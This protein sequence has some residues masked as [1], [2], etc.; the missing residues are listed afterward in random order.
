MVLQRK[1]FHLIFVLAAFGA[2]GA[3]STNKANIRG[4]SSVKVS[5]T[6]ADAK[7]EQGRRVAKGKHHGSSHPSYGGCFG[8]SE[9]DMEG[10]WIF[11][12]DAPNCTYVSHE[13]STDQIVTQEEVDGGDSNPYDAFLIEQCDTYENLWIWDLSLSCDSESSLDNCNCTFAEELFAA[14]TLTCDDK[15]DCPEDCPICET[16]MTV[17]GCQDPVVRPGSR[18]ST[19]VV[20]YIVGASVIF[21]ILVL[22]T[23]HSYRKSQQNAELKTGLMDGEFPKDDS[24]PAN[25]QHANWEPPISGAAAA[26]AATG[27]Y[28]VG[29]V[30]KG[31]GDSETAS[32]G[33][34]PTIDEST[35][36][37]ITEGSTAPSIPV[38]AD[39]ESQIEEPT[40][41]AA[42]ASGASA[43]E[44]AMQDDAE[45]EYE[46]VS[47][48]Y[49][50]TTEYI[51]DDSTA[52]TVSVIEDSKPPINNE[53]SMMDEEDSEE[54]SKKLDGLAI[55]KNHLELM[56]RLKGLESNTNADKQLDGLTESND[57]TD[58]NKELD[59]PTVEGESSKR[60]SQVSNLTAMFE[61][62]NEEE[63]M[64]SLP[65]SPINSEKKTMDIDESAAPEMPFSEDI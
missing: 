54:S 4:S 6:A 65:S 22:G 16:C 45:Y 30:L 62:R 43:D 44:E 49:E 55:A 31:D 48:D 47:E 9:D 8:L 26:A 21:L 37:Q 57:I 19:S 20:L 23:F 39:L 7:R 12:D 32:D 27:A 35:T 40:R 18:L 61:A 17:I 46:T 64:K 58:A 34:V 59:G 11:E 53:E 2:E 14:G 56:A 24:Y 15:N 13:N 3:T 28:A 1:F 36:V 41:L 29:K 63:R 5:P 25:Q 52:P 60:P 51:T 42:A 38:S 10:Y 33:T 50:E